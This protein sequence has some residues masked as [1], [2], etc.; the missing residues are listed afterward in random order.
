MPDYRG[1]GGE[2]SGAAAAAIRNIAGG[3]TAYQ[4]KR[5]FTRKAIIG[6]I[7]A[8]LTG[9]AG[10]IKGEEGRAEEADAKNAATKK[11]IANMTLKRGKESM[12]NAGSRFL[13]DFDSYRDERD[14]AED[15]KT[16]RGIGKSYEDTSRPTGELAGE[17]LRKMSND[18]LATELPDQEGRWNRAGMEA[19]MGDAETLGDDILTAKRIIRGSG[20]INPAGVGLGGSLRR[21]R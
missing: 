2:M 17:A 1:G 8:G 19:T 21:G 20:G 16:I 6:G 5:D 12:S 13:S 9:I 14:I 15:T 4:R 18:K 10:I 3:N 11:A 7:Q